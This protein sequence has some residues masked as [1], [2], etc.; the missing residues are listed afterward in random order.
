MDMI[1]RWTAGWMIGV[2]CL[3]LAS[4]VAPPPPPSHAGPPPVPPPQPEAMGKPPVTTTP[5]I[6][7]PGHWDWSGS[8]YVW[9]P[10]DFEPSGGHSNMYMPGYWAQSPNGGWAWQP[11]HWM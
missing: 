2:V 8:G 11:A 6:W 1:N 4:C 9:A 3:A 7:R 10:G 5:L